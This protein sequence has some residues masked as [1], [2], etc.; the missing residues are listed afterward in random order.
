MRQ[1]G[2][3]KRHRWTVFMLPHCQNSNRRTAACHPA[4]RLAWTHRRAFTLIEVLVVIALITL[5]AALML[6]ALDKAKTRGH[7]I[8]CLNHLKQLAVCWHL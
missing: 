6:P 1:S 5:L 3:R 2:V 4:G 7:Q 8:A